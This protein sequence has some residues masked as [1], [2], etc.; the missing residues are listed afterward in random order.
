ML[1]KTQGVK[2]IYLAAK[3]Y[4]AKAYELYTMESLTDVTQEQRMKWISKIC[5]LSYK[6]LKAMEVLRVSAECISHNFKCQGCGVRVVGYGDKDF[7][8]LDSKNFS[9]Q[10]PDGW[11]FIPD[12]DEL[13]CPLC[14]SCF[15]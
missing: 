13:V 14:E 3:K 8:I 6:A 1:N 4:H 9:L 15:A 10:L 7:T 2:D 5:R 12:T 11:S